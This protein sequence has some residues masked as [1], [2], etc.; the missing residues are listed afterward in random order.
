MNSKNLLKVV[1]RGAY[2]KFSHHIKSTLLASYPNILAEKNGAVGIIT[3]NR[4]KA[5]NALCD[6]LLD[7]LIHAAT[8]FDA[9][10]SVGAIVITVS[11]SRFP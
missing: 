6:D 3:L 11:C 9:D 7:D 4:P 10:E 5:L 1:R 2:R 8:A